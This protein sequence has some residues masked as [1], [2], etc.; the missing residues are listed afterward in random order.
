M[1]AVDWFRLAGTAERIGMAIVGSVM[2]CV[3][4]C[5]FLVLHSLALYWI[6]GELDPR[7]RSCVHVGVGATAA[8]VAA[9][10]VGVGLSHLRAMRGRRG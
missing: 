9:I 7:A 6:Y 5:W 8:N 4:S 10:A 3:L 2:V 1:S